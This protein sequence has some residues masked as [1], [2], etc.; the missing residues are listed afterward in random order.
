MDEWIQ[1]S[2]MDGW[3]MKLAVNL[4]RWDIGEEIVTQN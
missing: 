4:R 3:D 1:P 2:T